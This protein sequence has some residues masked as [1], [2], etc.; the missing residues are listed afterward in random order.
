[1]KRVTRS[2]TLD[3]WYWTLQVGSAFTALAAFAFLVGTTLVGRTIT[4]RDAARLV[5]L[6]TELVAAKTALSAQQERT[7]T[8][9][10]RFRE[11]MLPRQIPLMGSNGDGPTRAAIRSEMANFVGTHVEIRSVAGSE[12]EGLAVA[13][14]A[15]ARSAGWIADIGAAL[16]PN[17]MAAITGGVRVVTLEPN[18]FGSFFDPPGTPA[19]TPSVSPLGQ[20]AQALV[21]FLEL[22]LGGPH[23][24]MGVT[25]SP[26]TIRPMEGSADRITVMVGPIAVETML[27]TQLLN[28]K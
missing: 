19:R 24:P 17:S 20:A 5:S 4:R 3:D 2:M 9:F 6:E 11:A 27:P 18:L 7:A 21:K 13:I 8:A 15:V 12:P 28:L 22:D 26:E 25:W 1:M 14:A 23:R 10:M 16:A